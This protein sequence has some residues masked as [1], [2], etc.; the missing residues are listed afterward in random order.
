MKRI[1]VVNPKNG[2]SMVVTYAKGVIRLFMYGSNEPCSFAGTEDE[3]DNEWSDP[4]FYTDDN[5]VYVI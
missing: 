2:R 4:E 1:R 5:E 3:F